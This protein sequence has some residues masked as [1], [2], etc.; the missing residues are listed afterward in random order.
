MTA[1]GTA[2]DLHPLQGLAVCLDSMNRALDSAPEG[3]LP[4][5]SGAE[6]DLLETAILDA[7][8]V[9]SRIAELRLRLA[10]AADDAQTAERDASSGSDAW[11]AKLTGTNA[12]VIRGGLWL[13]RLLTN[14]YPA[15]RHAFAVGDLAEPHVRVIIRAAE[16]MP[17]AVTDAERDQAVTTLVEKAIARQMSP[18]TLRRAARRMLEAINTKYADQHE[19]DL[20]NKEE[21]HAAAETWLTLSDNGDGTYSGRFVIPELH[22]HLLRTV[23]EHLSSPRRMSRNHAGQPVTDPTIADVTGGYAGLN[24]SERLGHALTEL[25]EHLPTDGL[26]QHGRVGAS[27]VIHLDHDRLLDGLGSARLDTGTQISAGQARRLACNTG[28]IPGIFGTTSVPLDLGRETRLHTKTQR[29]GLSATH[30][31][32]AAEGCERPFA[33]CE[34]HHPHAWA[35]GGRTDLTGIP[36]C[37]WHHHRAHD[38]RYDLR[39]LPTGEIRYRRRR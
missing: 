32:C 25:C 35:S 19:A 2:L 5:V 3:P 34:I 17:T 8:K 38:N 15:V 26:A 6:L 11:L 7:T 1:L 9:S 14:R 20:L 23:L 33:W 30:D 21:T 10:R 13:A 29:I 36:L 37:G 22:A 16:Q 39:T 28:L 31:S 18:K 4:A 24:W 27:I 12:A